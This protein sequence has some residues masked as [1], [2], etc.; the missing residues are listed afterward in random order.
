MKAWRG[1]SD[2]G[3]YNQLLAY[4]NKLDS[5]MCCSTN[6]NILS[7]F[8]VS[9]H[10]SSVQPHSLTT[11]N[12]YYFVDHI[13]MVPL[14]RQTSKPEVESLGSQHW[15]FQTILPQNWKHQGWSQWLHAI[16]AMPMCRCGTKHNLLPPFPCPP[17]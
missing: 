4:L 17:V 14:S 11:R 2:S 15:R 6:Q 9:Q 1:H 12:C 8:S 16:L 3:Q 10:L 7:W 13:L 5:I